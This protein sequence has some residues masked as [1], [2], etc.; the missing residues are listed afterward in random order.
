MAYLRDGE[1]PHRWAFCTLGET[2]VPEGESGAP[3][4]LAPLSEG[5]FYPASSFRLHARTPLPFPAYL[6]MSRNHFNLEWA[7]ERRLKNAVMVLEWV[8]SLEKLAAL[9]TAAAAMNVAQQERVDSALRLL[10]FDSSGRCSHWCSHWSPR[11]VTLRIT[12]SCHARHLTL[13]SH[14][15]SSCPTPPARTKP[16]PSQVHPV[17]S[18]PGPDRPATSCQLSFHIIQFLSSPHPI[19][20]SVSQYIPTCILEWRGMLLG[21]VEVGIRVEA[22]YSGLE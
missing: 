8:P 6:Q 2:R 3:P 11:C 14:R 18:H 5:T 10:D 21:G 17:S 15:V 4:Q 7:G 12:P 22:V 16:T 1:E 9:P 20:T 19:P 13:L